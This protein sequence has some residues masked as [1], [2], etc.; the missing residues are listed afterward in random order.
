VFPLNEISNFESP[1]H[2]NILLQISLITKELLKADSCILLHAL[3]TVSAHLTRF[4]SP[5]NDAFFVEGMNISFQGR[6]IFFN[7]IFYS[8]DSLVKMSSV[9]ISFNLDSLLFIF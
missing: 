6:N 3:R 7:N 9:N 8:I 5:A 1:I 2:T 4:P